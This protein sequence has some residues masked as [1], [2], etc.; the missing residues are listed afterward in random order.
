MSPGRCKARGMHFIG[1]DL[2]R[3]HLYPSILLPA[4]FAFWVTRV[5]WGRRKRSG[6]Y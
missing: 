2:C 5:T 4:G 1:K 3:P 6:V